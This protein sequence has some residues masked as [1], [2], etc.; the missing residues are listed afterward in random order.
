MFRQLLC[1]LVISSGVVAQQSPASSKSHATF[2]IAG[3]VVND[4]TGQP[5]SGIE[6]AIGKAEDGNAAQTQIT[7]ADGHFDFENLSA[8]KYWLAAQGRGFFPQRFDQHEEFSTAIAVGPNLEPQR[9]IF[10]MQPDASLTGSVIDDQNE[11]VRGAQITLFR[12]G[13]QNGINSIELASQAMTDERGLYHFSHQRPDTYYV[14]VEAQPWYAENSFQSGTASSEGGMTAASET[15]RSELDVTYPVTFYSGVT[16]PNAA[17]AVVLKP[18]ERSVADITLSPVPALHLRISGVDASQ[19]FS[20]TLK[21]RSFGDNPLAI[22][23]RFS[24][25]GK[26]E[27]DIDGVPPGDFD[28]TVETGSNN[29]MI[30]EK[31]MSIAADAETDL[32]DTIAAATVSGVVQ[33]A[34]GKPLPEGAYVQFVGRTARQTFGTRVSSQG[35]FQASDEQVRAGNYDIYVFDPSNTPSNEVVR[36]ISATGA[37]VRGHQV[38]IIP[39]ASARL[40]ITVSQGSGRV[41]GTVVRDGTAFAGAMVILVPNDIEHNA[42]LVRRDQSDSDG[43]FSLYNVLPGKYTVVALAN[44]WNL[45]WMTPNIL[46]PYL[47]RG[48][49]VEVIAHGRY[50]LKINAQ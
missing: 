17:T 4:I 41:D 13:I 39:G 37:K 5:L 25:A 28:L 30:R 33:F 8:H 10:R 49:T 35:E 9:L 47:Q 6:V 45:E 36:S 3:T 16:D 23:L 11:A 12:D 19:G 18:G 14:A 22:P 43:T 29:R 15:A 34:S 38:E 44:S 27:I 2:Q 26:N 32:S 7:G 42:S 1:L 48:E 31:Q 24:T 40:T 21:Q 20:A 50:T 46:Q